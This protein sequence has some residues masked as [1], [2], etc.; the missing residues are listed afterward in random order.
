MNFNLGEKGESAGEE[1]TLQDIKTLL[2]STGLPVTYR[3]WPDQQAPALPWICYLVTGS[4]NFF[5]DGKMYL[6]VSM[7]SVELYTALISPAL[8][9]QLEQALQGFCWQKTIT[10]IDT[11]KVYQISYEIEVQLNA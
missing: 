1:M 7:V 5:A 4:N 9:Q 6:G 3:A 10:Y 11:E 2:E 8:E